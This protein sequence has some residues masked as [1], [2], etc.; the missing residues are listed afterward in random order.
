LLCF[1]AYILG[2]FF[3]YQARKEINEEKVFNFKELFTAG[4]INFGACIAIY[5]LVTGKIVV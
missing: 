3:Y 5:L 1:T 2:I 4:V